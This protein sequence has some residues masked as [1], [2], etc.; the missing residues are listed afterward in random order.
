M[1]DFITK[2]FF[3]DIASLCQNQVRLATNRISEFDIESDNVTQL[4]DRKTLLY[5]LS[6]IMAKLHESMPNLSKSE[7]AIPS[8]LNKHTW[9][10]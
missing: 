2:N 4:S 6:A 1:T 9:K 7:T 10:F 5:I 8:N 3:F